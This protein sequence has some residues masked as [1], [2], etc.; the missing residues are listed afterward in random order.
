MQ[1]HIHPIDVNGELHGEHQNLF[2]PEFR[3]VC[4]QENSK[5]HRSRLEHG[6]KIRQVTLPT[7]RTHQSYVRMTLN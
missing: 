3:E 7:W 1:K 6:V 2:P 5:R 4:V